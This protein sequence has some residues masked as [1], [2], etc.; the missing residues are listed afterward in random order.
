[1]KLKKTYC[2]V[3]FLKKVPNVICF[4]YELAYVQHVRE[5]VYLLAYYGL[6]IRLSNIKICQW[7]P[8]VHKR[9]FLH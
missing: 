2:V 8:H 5:V 6:S 3:S 9:I 1:M 4:N 7:K